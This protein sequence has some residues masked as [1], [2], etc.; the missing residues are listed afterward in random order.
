MRERLL[1]LI[2]GAALAACGGQ[3]ETRPEPE[4]E[5]Q[6]EATEEAP[7]EPKAA[8]SRLLP[9]KAPESDGVSQDGLKLRVQESWLAARMAQPTQR[10]IAFEAHERGARLSKVPGGTS[11]AGLGFQEG[12]VV[13][14]VEG[15]RVTADNAAAMLLGALIVDEEID[16][17]VQR[18]ARADAWV[19]GKVEMR[20]VQAGD[21]S[22]GAAFV[23]PGAGANTWRVAPNA[24]RA[25]LATGGHWTP[26]T[27]KFSVQ[28][29]G[30]RLVGVGPKSLMSTLGFKSGDVI[31]TVN[32]APATALDP[33]WAEAGKIVVGV[34][35]EGGDVQLTYN[36][37]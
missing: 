2:A 5:P 27:T 29:S 22:H 19:E 35:R 24:A 9:W 10:L 26:D 7:A 28:E 37:E 18:P 20:L 25:A 8:T 13:V 23:Q 21:A 1:M 3:P 16:V 14:S 31:T 11:L 36:L 6:P 34:K 4:P 15:Q 33:A 12:D 32:G 17:H 30:V